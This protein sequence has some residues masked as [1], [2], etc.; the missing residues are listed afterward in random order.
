MTPLTA[1]VFP[2]APPPVAAPSYRR[3]ARQVAADVDF[4]GLLAAT[5][6][7]LGRHNESETVTLQVPFGSGE[8]VRVTGLRVQLGDNPTF[9][10]AVDA[11]RSAAK[12]DLHDGHACLVAAIGAPSIGVSALDTADLTNLRPTIATTQISLIADPDNGILRCDYSVDRLGD[13]AADCVVEQLL[14]VL[15]HGRRAPDV[16]ISEYETPH[17]GYGV[18]AATTMGESS[19]AL[20]DLIDARAA[21]D[22]HRIAVSC[23]GET[24]TYEALRQESTRVAC[25][26]RALG[27]GPGARV[28]VH[29]DRAVHLPVVLLGVLKAG[30]A[31]VPLDADT[32]PA[33]KEQIV[34]RAD[35]AL[36]IVA[37]GHRP[38]S[39]S[40]TIIRLADLLG[41]PSTGDLDPLVIA[42]SEP[43]YILFTSGSTGS[44]KGVSVSHRNVARLFSTTG[45][46]F[47]FNQHDVWLNSASAAFDASVWEIFG[48]LAHGATVVIAER[49]STRD[50]AAMVALVEEQGVTMLTIS[51]TAFNGFRDAALKVGAALSRLRF[52]ILWA[53]PLNPVVLSTWFGRWGDERPAVFN[54]YGITETTVHST[55]HRVRWADTRAHRSVIGRGLPDTPVYLLDPNG[56][57]LP[58]GVPG[59]IVVGGPGVADGGYVVA[60]PRDHL[61]YQPDPFS[62]DPVAR[63]YRSGD[64]GRLLPDGT[65]E[66]LGRFDAQVKIRGHRVELG[67]IEAALMLHPAV[68]GAR[69]WLH[70]PAGRPPM[71]AAA[72]ISTAATTRRQLR[73]FVETR[74]P[75]YMVPAGIVH[76]DAFPLTPNGKIDVERLPDPLA[77]PVR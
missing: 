40:T 15:R 66:Y 29:L 37:D 3:S 23:A 33:R 65:I 73:D 60:P 71:L 31:Y 63:R 48:A 34:E 74:L 19:V 24:L 52:V 35:L 21:A 56:R 20:H 51:P 54:M 17:H 61:R 1:S 8:D 22:P 42:G 62:A 30:A 25:A 49:E 6:M 13:D 5:A 45:E 64:K 68:S 39:S 46:I 70:R 57:P 53:E 72:V 4:E 28:G 59:E 27:V 11:V 47:D 43:A 77:Q 18:A 14:L 9:S 32:P 75:P 36:I 55:I 58:C 16:P 10:R 50:P 12:T 38:W 2:L 7:L 69:A 41:T 67:E 44:P 26:L 76:V